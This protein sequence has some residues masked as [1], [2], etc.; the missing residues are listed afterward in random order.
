MKLDFDKVAKDNLRKVRRRIIKDW[1]KLN[2]DHVRVRRDYEVVLFSSL[3]N[4]SKE[5]NNYITIFYGYE[6]L[7][8]NKGLINK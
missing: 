8:G 1:V 4:I 5:M 7:G 6:Q 2:F 3:W